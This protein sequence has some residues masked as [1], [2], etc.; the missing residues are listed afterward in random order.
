MIKKDCGY[1][2]ERFVNLK[3]EIFDCVI[4]LQIA[5]NPNECGSCGSIFCASCIQDWMTIKCEHGCPNRCANSRGDIKPISGAV[6]KLY[7]N[8]DIKCRFP[9]CETPVK[10]CELDSHEQ[11]CQVPRCCNAE[12]CRRHTDM[13]YDLFKKEFVCN[14][15]CFL[16][17]K[18]KEADGNWD[19]ALTKI[20]QYAYQLDA[21][22]YAARQFESRLGATTFLWSSRLKGTNIKVSNDGISVYLNEEGFNFRTIMSDTPLYSGCHYWMIIIDSDSKAEM[23]FGISKSRDFN[24]N[25][26]FSDYEFG[27]AYYTI[28]QL[29]QND[30]SLGALYGKQ[31]KKEGR[32]GVFLDMNKGTLSF[33]LNDEYLGVAFKDEKLKN[34]PIWPAAALINQSGF[35]LVT[36]VEAPHYFIEP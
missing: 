29:R 12:Q 32:L 24:Y 28:G 7:R 16:L 22:R 11:L 21:I 35:I 13:K 33:A 34:G 14:E 8:L 9:Q 25:T 15:R 30:K 20:K 27:Y 36:N 1:D 6:L 26:A 19:E 10:L 18:L 31:F 5:N 17:K 4:C 3:T 2:K 23:K